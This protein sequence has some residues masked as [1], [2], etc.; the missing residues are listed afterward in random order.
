MSKEEQFSPHERN[1]YSQKEQAQIRKAFRRKHGCCN[2]LNEWDFDSCME[3][4]VCRYEPKPEPA[5]LRTKDRMPCA[6]NGGKLCPY[7]NGSGTCFGFCIKGI[8]KEFRERKEK[9]KTEAVQ[10]RRNRRR[11]AERSVHYE[12]EDKENE[13]H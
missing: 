6:R 11:T 2:C 10:R 4:G 7:G 3:M 12:K 1:R 8:M 5:Y 9:S 13:Q